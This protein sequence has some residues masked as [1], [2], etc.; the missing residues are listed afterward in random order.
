[1]LLAFL[2]IVFITIMHFTVVSSYSRGKK[3]RIGFLPITCH[4]LLPVAMERDKWFNDHVETIK[5]SS[6]PDMIEA[7]KGRELDATFIL[8]PIALSL[9][10]QDV[11][12]KIVLLGHRNGTGLVVSKKENIHNADDFRGKTVAIPIRFSTQNLALHMFLSDGSVQASDVNLVE[13]PPPDMPSA[14]TSGGIDAYIVGEPYVAQA[15]LANSGIMLHRVQDIWPD[16]ISSLMIVRDQ[17]LKDKKVLMDQLIH[18][19]YSQGEWIESHREEAARIGAAFF[20]LPDNLL[21]HVLTARPTR[22][23]YRRLIPRQ[24][25]LLRIGDLMVRYELLDHVPPC[26]LYLGWRHA[27]R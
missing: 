4:L 11:P 24:D 14:L 13:L 6:W 7:I 3:L 22:V 12:V 8:A 19:L 23:V 17:V 16:F 25:E 20:G 9:M 5:F 18:V 15:E 10:D 2:W 1:M 26:R 27:S 21:I